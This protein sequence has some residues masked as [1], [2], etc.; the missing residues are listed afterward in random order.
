MHYALCGYVLRELRAVFASGAAG[1]LVVVLYHP[2]S[3]SIQ[4]VTVQHVP[5]SLRHWD[6]D[7]TRSVHISIC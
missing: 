6:A 3:F 4:V 7:F 1:L 2:G 5:C